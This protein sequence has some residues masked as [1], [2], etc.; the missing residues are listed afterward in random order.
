MFQLKIAHLVM[1]F[2][3]EMP[4]WGRVKVRKK[5]TY[6]VLRKFLLTPQISTTLKYQINTVPDHAEKRQNKKRHDGENSGY[7]EDERTSTDLLEELSSLVVEVDGEGWVPLPVLHHLSCSTDSSSM[8][9]NNSNH[10]QK[11]QPKQ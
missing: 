4:A 1:A 8:S 11:K 5:G 9:N 7:A 3:N 6:S 2:S 10:H